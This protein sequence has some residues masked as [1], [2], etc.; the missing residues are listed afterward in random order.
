MA[1]DPARFG[2]GQRQD[3]QLDERGALDKP[4]EQAKLERVDEVLGV[5]EHDRLGPRF[6]RCFVLGQGTIKVV[7]TIGL[8]RRTVGGD[9]DWAH[10]RIGDAGYG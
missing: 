1:A 4:V 3:G 6:A 5:V 2:I 9:G 8:G 7:E 10:A